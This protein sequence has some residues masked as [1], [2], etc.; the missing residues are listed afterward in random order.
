[1]QERATPL[2]VLEAI[3]RSYGEKEA[4]V[5]VLKGLNLTIHSGEF[6]AIVGAS[7]S[8]KSTLMNILGCL[9]RPSSGKYVFKGTDVSKLDADGL[10]RLRRESFGFVFQ[11]YNLIHSLNASQNVEMPAVYAGLGLEARQERAK[12]L[13]IYLGLEERLTYRPGQLSGGQQQRVSIARALM[14]GGQIIL[15][16]EPTGALDSK[17]GEDVMHLLIELWQAGH[18]LILITHSPEVARHANRVIEIKDGEIIGDTTREE[19][20]KAVAFNTPLPSKSTLFFELAEAMKS[21]LRALRM[22]IFRT[23]LTL[24]GIVIGVASVIVMLAIGDGAKKEVMD[25]ISS[26]GTNLLVIRPGSPN[27]RGFA[28]IAT[29]VPQDMKAVNTMDNILGT[30]PESRRNTT[31]RYGNNDTQTPINTTSYALPLIR[32]WPVALGTFFTEEDEENLAKVVVLGQTVA[33]S[34]FGESDPLGAF[35]L[36][37]NILFQVIGVMAERGASAMGEDEDDVVFMPYTTGSLHILGYEYLRNITVAVEDVKGIDETQKEIEALLLARHG[38]EDFRIRNM[39]SLIENVSETQNTLTILLGSIAGISLL[40]GG[41]GVMNIM[42]VSVTE[43]TKEIGIRMANGARM[44]NI[45]QQFL[46]EAIVVSALGGLIG[47][48]IGL[49]VTGAVGH[50]EV[51]VVYSVWPVALA[52]G[53]SFLTGLVF[54]YL[55]AKKAAKLDPVVALASE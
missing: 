50:F 44:R 47:V 24:L 15:A 10:A 22:N 33:T 3:T 11:S 23:I 6:V 28:N 7:G 54:G 55:P 35:V 17:S 13:L 2:I 19:T 53:C 39:A 18:T 21:S 25:R 32:N 20:R 38:V 30:M 34:L 4:A 48:F 14:N 41:I 43:R 45:M 49:V 42:L 46:I 27:T 52:F 1:M 8:G 16:D 40:V 12:E 29:L 5:Q 9:D 36:V 26:L 51:S 37:D 31:V